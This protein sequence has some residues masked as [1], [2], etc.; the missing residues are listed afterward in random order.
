MVYSKYTKLWILCWYQQRICPSTMAKY[1]TLEGIQ[2]R[3]KGVAKF[4]KRFCRTGRLTY[5][6]PLVSSI[7]FI[8]QG[9]IARQASS[10]RRTV[11]TEEI[12]KI[13]EDQMHHDNKTTAS[14]L[15]VLLT[16]LGYS[17][18]LWT[19][20]CCRTSLGW[21]FRGSTYCQLM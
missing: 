11:I 17:L 8:A 2:V 15:H 20:L 3:R 14:Q 5:L 7:I 13:V 9:T 21:T 12:Q 16:T 18:N 1:L 10:C 4:I 19:I 6:N